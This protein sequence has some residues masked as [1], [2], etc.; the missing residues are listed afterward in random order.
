MDRLCDGLHAYQVRSSLRV[1]SEAV[2]WGDRGTFLT[3]SDTLT[4]GAFT[5]LFRARP[6]AGQMPT[7]TGEVFLA[8]G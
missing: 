4:S 8:E 5:E 1:Q 2:R 7:P 3:D 6:L